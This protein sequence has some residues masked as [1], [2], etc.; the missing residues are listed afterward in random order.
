[1]YFKF[2]CLIVL[3]GNYLS[4]LVFLMILKETTVD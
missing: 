4:L 1:M 2:I 3:L